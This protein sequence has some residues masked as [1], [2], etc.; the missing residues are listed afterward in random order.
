MV[1]LIRVLMYLVSF[2]IIAYL[3]IY[4]DIGK[5]V[6]QMKSISI[7]LVLLLF[8]IA[9]LYTFLRIYRFY[10]L[11]RKK[12]LISFRS[13]TPIFCYGIALSNFVPGRFSE[14]IR[15]YLLKKEKGIP[16]TFSMACVFFERLSDV[17]ILF[18]FSFLLFLFLKM[19]LF[20]LPFIAI[21]LFLCVVLLATQNEKI[22][23]S[24]VKVLEL[25]L[26]SLK[27]FGIKVKIFG[28]IIAGIKN[29]HREIK[30]SKNFL[31]PLII[32]AAIWA[33]DGMTFYLP[34]ISL[35]ENVNFFF[36]LSVYSFSLLVGLITFLP[37]G[38]GSVEAS[39][40]FF[41]TYSGISYQKAIVSIILGRF[42][43][44]G[45]LM[46][47]GTLMPPFIKKEK[48]KRIT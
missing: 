20:A 8:I 24:F 34:L 14:P 47:Y 48:V 28:E 31:A 25:L 12:Y 33:I 13:L 38:F 37:G 21:F 2:G 17:L 45:I 15:A 40:L 39:M 43:S 42:F 18:L 22:Y 3:L 27:K 16:F 26:N 23:F 7:E 5:I 46:L 11:I 41:F 6:E 1:D 9:L 4:G 19:E 35:G 30:L 10:F 36:V 44:L 32:S 29:L